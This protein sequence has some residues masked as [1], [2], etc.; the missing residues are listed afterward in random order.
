MQ[1]VKGFCKNIK[2][3]FLSKDCVLL[4]FLFMFLYLSFSLYDMYFCKIVT[5]VRSGLIYSIDPGIKFNSIYLNMYTLTLK[6]PF[7]QFLIY[8]II[9]FFKGFIYSPGLIASMLQ[10]IAQS[11]VV[12]FIYR[13]LLDLTQKRNVSLLFSILYGFSNAAL[14][15]AVF[16]DLYVWVALSQIIFLSYF[17]HCYKNN[18][19]QLD[20]KNIVILSFLTVVSFGIN[21]VNIVSCILLTVFLIFKV[22]MNDRKKI[23][24]SI[25][26][27]IG[28]TALIV[29][30]FAAMQTFVYNKH[31]ERTIG[32]VDFSFTSFTIYKVN[33]VIAGTYVEP[34]HALNPGITDHT[35]LLKMRDGSLTRDYVWDHLAK[36]DKLDFLAY[37]PSLLF[38]YVSLILYYR[39]RNK[40]NDKFIMKSLFAIV[41]L[42]TY[43]NFV[44]FS[45]RC[46]LFSLN[47]FPFLIILLGLVYEHVKPII[48]N[49]VVGLFILYEVFINI[50]SLFKIHDFLMTKSFDD[51]TY[52]LCATAAAV[53]VASIWLVYLLFRFLKNRGYFLTVSIENPYI[54][55]ISIYLI[56]AILYLLCKLLKQMLL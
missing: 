25:A 37:I 39:N 48:R 34:F 10:S 14:V 28:I 36:K 9:L 12:D 33:N 55:G 23:L 16:G 3:F 41:L 24:T 19:G 42:Y 21:L 6:H 27:F 7:A 18:T 1:F 35:K 32:I 26:K 40:Y 30:V 45:D 47:F 51:H 53:F 20:I 31:Q 17:L 54:F 52:M 43:F 11:A 5:Q 4:F 46:F 56:L 49:G 13:I 29:M 8:P 2:E 44:F 15:F 22:Y 38:L 50:D